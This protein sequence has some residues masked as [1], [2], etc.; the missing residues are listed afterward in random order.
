MTRRVINTTIN[1]RA[2]HAT[3]PKIPPQAVATILFNA[4]QHLKVRLALSWGTLV[5]LISTYAPRVDVMNKLQS[6]QHRL[7]SCT[8]SFLTANECLGMFTKSAANELATSTFTVCKAPFWIM[9]KTLFWALRPR[10]V[11]KINAR[12]RN[13]FLL[14]VTIR[15]FKPL[16]VSYLHVAK[17]HFNV[18]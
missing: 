5:D 11:I 9:V 15:N 8:T 17:V 7:S 6:G 3:H 16:S 10:F 1:T 13:I 4:T 14:I 2:M 12:S 18:T